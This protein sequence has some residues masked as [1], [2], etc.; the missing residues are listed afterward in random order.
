[1]TGPEDLDFAEALGVLNRLTAENARLKQEN[2]EQLARAAE[3]IADYEASL[4]GRREQAI[5]LN[6]RLLVTS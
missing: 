2:A 3:R 5:A 6:C 1:M 4:T